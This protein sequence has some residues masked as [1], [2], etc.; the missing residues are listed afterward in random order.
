MCLLDGLA[1][2]AGGKWVV[3]MER[4][5]QNKHNRNHLISI[6]LQNYYDYIE[7]NFDV[8]IFELVN[9]FFAETGPTHLEGLQLAILSSSSSS[10]H[11]DSRMPYINYIIYGRLDSHL[12]QAK[13]TKPRKAAKFSN[14]F[15][16]IFAHSIAIY[17]I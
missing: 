2:P 8:V 12:V 9:G 15:G 11:I 4:K 16:Y 1:Q 17:C 5:R 6:F 10:N 3:V 14:A 13:C 7:N